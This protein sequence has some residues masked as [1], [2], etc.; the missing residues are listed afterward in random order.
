M[1][2]LPPSVS[3]RFEALDLLRGVAAVMIVAFHAYWTSAE[4]NPWSK[5]WLAVDLFFALSGFVLAHAY[6]DRL[7][8]G[9]GLRAFMTLRLARLYPLYIAGTLIGAALWWLFEVWDGASPDPGLLGLMLGW[10]ALFLPVPPGHSIEPEMFYPLNGPAWTLLFELMVNL[11]LALSA[12]FLRPTVLAAIVGGAAVWL[13][14]VAV[15]RQSLDVGW[16]WPT[17]WDGGARAAFSFF[18]GVALYRLHLVRKA[19]AVGAWLIAAIFVGWITLGHGRGWWFDLASVTL[20]FPM[21]IWLAASAKSGPAMRRIGLWSGYVSYPVYALHVPLLDL[22]YRAF[23]KLAGN[24]FPD[25]QALAAAG[26]VLAMIAVAW[27]AARF[28]DDPVRRWLARWIAVG[29]VSKNTI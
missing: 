25:R 22:Y 13:V 11:C 9:L 17:L 1:A 10:Q 19:P 26:Y 14:M 29:K 24:P 23:G 5:G 4:A 18:A 20:V 27:L 28:Y 3:S 6:L 15:N 12:R 21:L 2:I 7:K 8:T 16:S